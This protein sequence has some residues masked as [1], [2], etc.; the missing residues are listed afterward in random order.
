MPAARQGFTLVEVLIYVLLFAMILAAVSSLF[1]L[2]LRTQSNI[3]AERDVALET[4]RIIGVVSREIQ[5]ARSVYAPTSVFDSHPGQL[6]LETPGGYVD[7]FVCGT[8]LCRKA[9]GQS[10]AAVSCSCVSMERLMF[11]HVVSGP[12]S[13]VEIDL[14]VSSNQANLQS[15]FTAAPRPYED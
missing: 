13:S 8:Q 3:K 1:I 12:F 14:T 4:Q 7:F 10:P 5:G 2:L 11:R 6:S 15:I 9:E